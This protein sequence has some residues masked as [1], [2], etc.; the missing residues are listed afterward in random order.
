MHIYLSDGNKSFVDWRDQLHVEIV[1]G[2]L[3]E[4][5]DVFVR[6]PL[7][8]FVADADDEVTLF[9]PTRLITMKQI[10]I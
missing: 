8:V 2:R 7:H 6:R 3:D 5:D 9:H 1:S 10:F 4:S